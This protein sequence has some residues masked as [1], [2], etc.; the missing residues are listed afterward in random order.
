MVVDL[1]YQW[2]RLTH[3]RGELKW[4]RPFLRETTQGP[5]VERPRHCQKTLARQWTEDTV[6][7]AIARNTINRTSSRQAYGLVV[8]RS[9]HFACGREMSRGLSFPGL[10]ELMVLH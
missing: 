1:V 6:R 7:V 9:V 2:E 10:G 8:Q 3:E 5:E 4:F